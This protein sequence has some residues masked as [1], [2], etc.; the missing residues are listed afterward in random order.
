MVTAFSSLTTPLIP[1]GLAMIV[2]GTVANV[3][4]GKLF[5]SGLGIG[6][7]LCV[8]MMVLVAVISRGRGYGQLRTNRVTAAEFW[9]ALRGAL[10]PLCLPVL[11]IG[12]IRLGVCTATEA[13][14]V[15]VIY[16]L[17]L[18]F[19]YREI[20][21]RDVIE[22][23]KETV[24]STAGVMLIVGAAS[25]FS[26][27]MTK[28]QL[29]QAMAALMVN[30]IHNKY[31]FLLI[32]NILLLIA[33]M[34][35]EGNAIMLVLVPLMVPIAASYGIHEVQFAMIFIFN[36]AIGSITPPMGTCMF[37]TCG[38]TKCP[39]SDFIKESIPFFC[40][41]GTLLL[42]ITYIPFVSTGLVELIY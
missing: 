40:L 16:S 33:G 30:V 10:L 17:V 28:E 41:M 24:V 26:W 19:A 7:F 38:V 35:L 36:I 27:I 2:Y 3:S 14:A 5:V 6:V 42:L 20:H 1:P 15:A 18:G 34:F 13:G 8:T 11:I 9:T 32:T 25:C 4:I 22:G 39:T 23:L 21:L 29:P 37:V 31:L 12:G